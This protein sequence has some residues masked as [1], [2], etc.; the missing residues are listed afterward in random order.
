[1]TSTT[2]W[3]NGAVQASRPAPRWM[4][5]VMTTF[6]TWSCLTL[7][8][9]EVVDAGFPMTG[10]GG[11]GEPNLL[12]AAAAAGLILVGARAGHARVTGTWARL[13]TGPITVGSTLGGMACAAVLATA[14]VAVS[15]YNAGQLQRGRLPATAAWQAEL[16][17]I[18]IQ[19]ATITWQPTAPDTLRN[20]RYLV[21]LDG[22]T[23]HAHVVGTDGGSI[24]APRRLIA[25]LRFED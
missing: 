19:T 13:T 20:G 9:G 8:A 2:A 1:M 25:D 6:I 24:S 23:V 11:V 16:A 18:G 12:V 4:S 15:L 17:G 22:Q 7:A 14:L 10:P 21:R 3:Q 5:W